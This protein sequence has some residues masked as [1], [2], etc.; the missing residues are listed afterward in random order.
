[1]AQSETAARELAEKQ[2][3]PRREAQKPH[4]SNAADV[5][6]E[7]EQARDKRISRRV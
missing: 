6:M 1:M 4:W 2:D 7:R 3:G 5:R